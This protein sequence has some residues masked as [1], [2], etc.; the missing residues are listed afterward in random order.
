MI[1]ETGRHGGLIDGQ[2][3]HLLGQGWR[4]VDVIELPELSYYGV[5]PPVSHGAVGSPP[6]KSVGK[7]GR[8]KVLSVLSSAEAVP[9]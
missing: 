7:L 2:G 5:S 8:R 4:D 1:A 6:T 9:A 3:T